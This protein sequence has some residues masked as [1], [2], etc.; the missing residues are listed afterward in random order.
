MKRIILATAALLAL[1]PPAFAQYR[2]DYYRDYYDDRRGGSYGRRGYDPYD[3]DD[4][5]RRRSRRS[6]RPYEERYER[7]SGRGGAG[8]VC[9]TAGGTCPHPPVP[10]GTGC[11]CTTSRGTF[12]GSVR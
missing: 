5:W 9:V 11:N 2:G 8:D 7:R 4:E 10:V 1:A 12:D 3:D 6:E